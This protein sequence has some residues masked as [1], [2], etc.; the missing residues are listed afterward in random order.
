MTDAMRDATNQPLAVDAQEL[1]KSD[2]LSATAFLDVENEWCCVVSLN[3]QQ[4]TNTVPL[5][6]DGS[7]GPFVAQS[8]SPFFVSGRQRFRLA[9]GAGAY[10]MRASRRELL[11]TP[12]R[13]QE[14]ANN[15][16]GFSESFIYSGVVGF[17]TVATDWLYLGADLVWRQAT[18]G[19][20]PA[21]MPFGRNAPDKN[22]A[23]RYYEIE[24]AFSVDV[25]TPNLQVVRD[26]GAAFKQSTLISGTGTPN[27]GNARVGDTY[28]GPTGPAALAQAQVLG[29]GLW[30][31]AFVNNVNATFTVQGLSVIRQ[32]F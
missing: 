26:A 18:I 30:T 3:P 28:S 10:V 11:S 16:A 7:S 8:G 19:S 6:V 24:W 31:L 14:Y 13:S 5:L 21:G 15:S 9:S 29:C 20:T 1:V 12:G 25:G 27:T 22:L 32:G 23:G 2:I 4:A 17:L